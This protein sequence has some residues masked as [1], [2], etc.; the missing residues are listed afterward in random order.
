MKTLVSIV[1]LAFVAGGAMACKPKPSAT[2][3]AV[4]RGQSAQ[5]A[6]VPSNHEAEQHAEDHNAPAGEVHRAEP[7]AANTVVRTDAMVNEKPTAMGDDGNMMNEKDA[8]T[9]HKACHFILT[10]M[11]A[12][13]K[14]PGFMKY[15]DRWVKKGAPKATI[16]NFESRILAWGNEEG[17]AESCRRWAR[18]ED[19]RTHF[20][21]N[22]KLA[23]LKQDAALPCNTFGQELDDDGWFPMAM[24]D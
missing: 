23:R 9:Y 8:G 24:E 22:S 12:C 20:A 1:G 7:T 17:R 15:Q 13:A 6:Q 16:K 19:T 5:S 2:D 18:R 14:D 3:N 11:V 21:S 4:D 10:R